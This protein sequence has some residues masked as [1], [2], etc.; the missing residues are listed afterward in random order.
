MGSMLALSLLAGCGLQTPQGLNAAQRSGAF[1]AREVGPLAP[2]LPRA[3]GER[4]ATMFSYIAMDDGLTG[5]A[6]TYL[7]SIEL[8]ATNRIHDLAFADFKGK[9]NSY[10]FYLQPST[11]AVEL[12]SPKSFLNATTKEVTS[13]DPAVLAATTEWAFSNY[14][15]KF[16]A[17]DIFAHGGGYLGQ[18]TDEKQPD[19]QRRVI[20]TVNDVGT[21]LR[22]GLKGQKLQLLNTLSCMMGNVEYAYEL[23][24]VAEVLIASEDSIYATNDSTNLFTAEL[25]RSLSGDNLDAKAIA[26][27]MVEFANSRSKEAGYMTISAVDLTKM[28][29]VA[30]SIKELSTVLVAAFPTE[31]DAI[32][33]AYDAVPTMNLGEFGNRDLWAFCT[34]LGDVKD[35]ALTKAATHVKAALKAALIATDDREGRRANGLSIAMPHRFKDMWIW[36]RSPVFQ[37]SLK[38]KFYQATGWGEF[39]NKVYYATYVK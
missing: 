11:R 4:A 17:M 6:K 13:N 8:S 23:S 3:E 12:T 35:P 22:T 25:N 32:L 5:F 36:K 30:S 18:G 33:K 20:M 39:L 28:D 29:A 9:D 27:H 19:N 1:G 37:D 26:S 7:K 14:P 21:A 31:G 10:L 34:R 24:D 16:K 2:E 38:G 15:A